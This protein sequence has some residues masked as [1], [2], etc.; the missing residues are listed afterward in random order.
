MPSETSNTARADTPGNPPGKVVTVSLRERK[1]AKTA[2][3]IYDGALELFAERPYSEVS[4]DD[5]CERAE[6]GRATFFRMY[7]SKAGLLAEFNRR[8]AAAA[9][10]KVEAAPPGTAAEHL[11]FVAAEIAAAWKSSGP[12]LAALAEEMLSGGVGDQM[13]TAGIGD[14]EP[15][16]H[17]SLFVLT[18]E[19]VRAGSRSGE[20]HLGGV[21][22]RVVAFITVTS[23]ATCVADWLM[24]PAG[25]NLQ[26]AVDRTLH[27]LL[28]GLLNPTV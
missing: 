15:N 10:A 5:I 4:V 26:T 1:K 13:L 7:G 16:I 25:R 8:V 23:L 2:A 17:D 3:A 19:I 18:A 20:F 6:V 21:P 12:G 24:R 11:G 27:I 9:R 22:T 28:R 14:D